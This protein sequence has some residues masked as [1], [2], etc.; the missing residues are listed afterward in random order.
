MNHD[1]LPILE[2]LIGFKSVTPRGKDAIEFI[3]NFLSN[4]GFKS[5][6]KCFGQGAD[7]VANLYAVFGNATPNICFAGHVDVVP[8]MNE[9]LWHANPFKMLIEDDII[10]GRGTVDM[11]GALACSLVAVA[12]FLKNTSNPN[13]SISFL[14]TSDE[15][16]DAVYG[17]KKMLEYIASQGHKIDFCILGEPTSQFKIGDT[18][19]I[20]RR[21][22]VNFDLTVKGKQGH[23]AYP[24]KA[25]NPIPVMARILSALTDK[26]FDSGSEYFQ[27]SN[28]EITSVDTGNPTSNIIPESVRAKFNIRF[29]DNHTAKDLNAMVMQIISKHCEDYDLKYTSSAAPFIQKYS[30][31]MQKFTKL[32]QEV[33]KLS[34]NIETSGGTSDARFIHSYCE[35]VEFGLNN[36]SAHQ[37]NEHTKISDL[38][39]LYN[40]YY[41]CL[42]LYASGE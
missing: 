10:Y 25:I 22:S 35:I 19:K 18:I 29:N 3:A 41:G 1:I 23:V 7:E 15:E 21:G 12:Q 16:G 5:E 34:P 9:H 8:P 28:L 14:L 30:P 24:E 26:K 38:Q 31:R 40:V 36:N 13:I 6:V 27:K 39:T 4:L 42:A 20:G 32:V 11:K 37:I 33:C 17:T 2:T